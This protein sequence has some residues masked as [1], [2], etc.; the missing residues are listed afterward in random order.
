MIVFHSGTLFISCVTGWLR[1]LI[2]Y[3]SNNW[4]R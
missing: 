2:V 4:L 3:Q 1:R